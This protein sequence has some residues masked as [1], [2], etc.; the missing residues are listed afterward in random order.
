[1]GT[2]QHCDVAG[3]QQTD[4]GVDG[5]ASKLLWSVVMRFHSTLRCCCPLSTVRRW[6]WSDWSSTC[7]KSECA[8]GTSKSRSGSWSSHR[9]PGW[10]W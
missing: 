8:G 2:N 6:S 10:W 1:M 4:D 7:V 3:Y 9:C 5:V